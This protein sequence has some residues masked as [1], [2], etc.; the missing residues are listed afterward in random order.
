MQNKRK[1]KSL[2]RFIY[3][4]QL[5]ITKELLNRLSYNRETGSPWQFLVLLDYESLSPFSINKIKS[6][7]HNQWR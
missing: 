2:N 5:Q 7:R 3:I 1:A 4:I 6:S